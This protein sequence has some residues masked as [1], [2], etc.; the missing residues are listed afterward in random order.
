[1]ICKLEI[2][3]LNLGC[4][5]NRFGVLAGMGWPYWGACGQNG[6]ICAVFLPWVETQGY[7]IGH[8]AG[9]FWEGRFA[10]GWFLG[11]I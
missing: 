1:L 2:K 6:G 9:V 11:G 3:V 4:Q 10:K 7:Q 5:I 8:S